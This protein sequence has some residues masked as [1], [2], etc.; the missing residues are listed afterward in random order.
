MHRKRTVISGL[1]AAAMAATPFAAAN[2]DPAYI[3]FP[4]FWPLI[5]L[6]AIVDAATSPIPPY[7]YGPPPCN[8]LPPPP[9]N[10]LSPPGLGVPGY[11]PPGYYPAR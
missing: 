8:C 4:P 2:A 6:A 5:T 9:A 3:A 10:Y 11:Y 7:Y 1:L